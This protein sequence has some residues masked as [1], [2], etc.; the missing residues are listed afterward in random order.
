M[1]NVGVFFGGR[2]V[3]REVS[4]L[5]GVMTL[6]SID[7]EKFNPVPIYIDGRGRFFTGDSLLD[8]DFYKKFDPKKLKA[9]TFL[10][11]DNTLYTVKKNKLKPLL[12]VAVFINC[13]HGEG[14]EDGTLEYFRAFCGVPFASPSIIPLAVAMDKGITKTFLLGLGVPVV[15]GQS[16]CDGGV[17]REVAKRI[18][19]PVIVKPD[20]LGSS[21]GISVAKNDTELDLAVGVGLRYGRSVLIERFLE[22]AVEI[23]CAVYESSEGVLKVSPCERPIKS[24]ELLSFEDKYTSGEREFPANIHKKIADKIKKI[25]AAVYTALKFEGIIRIDYILDGET[26][27]LNEI[28][29]V[30][31]SLAYYL[32]CDTLQEFSSV[33]TDLIRKAEQ[34]FAVESTFVKDFGSSILT[35]LGT[36]GSKRLSKK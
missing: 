17:A 16:V 1:K 9:V 3:E 8:I 26:V 21:I 35:G 20:K 33:L 13:V 36:K 31:G 30:P 23:N 22:N 12:S 6:N 28:N 24:N 32:F 11:G 34:N 19:Y 29:S 25:S 10:S 7:R 5:T 4:V 2:G 18:G 27:Y 14:G 15:Y